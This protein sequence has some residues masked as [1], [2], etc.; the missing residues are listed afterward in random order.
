MNPCHLSVVWMGASLFP[1]QK[2]NGHYL[3][4][5]LRLKLIISLLEKNVN[6]A[7]SAKQEMTRCWKDLTQA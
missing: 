4:F 6:R 7:S 5:S 2:K 3:Y 1:Q